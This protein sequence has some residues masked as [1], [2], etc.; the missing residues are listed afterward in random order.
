ML[1]C[2]RVRLW[3]CY[4]VM[5]VYVTVVLG[6]G[7][8]VIRLWLLCYVTVVFCLVFDLFFVWFRFS[9]MPQGHFILDEE[10]QTEIRFQKL[11]DVIDHYKE[12]LKYPFYHYIPLQP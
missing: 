12:A 11:E 3:L 6:Y 4:Q 2:G 9:R 7:C 8:Y 5:V 1:G 10:T